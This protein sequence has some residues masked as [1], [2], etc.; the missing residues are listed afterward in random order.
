MSNGVTITWQSTHVYSW[1]FPEEEYNR[2]HDS[3][4]GL[5]G[6]DFDGV[7]A[8]L[9]GEDCNAYDYTSERTIIVVKPEVRP[10]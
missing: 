5:D 3:E 6:H 2:H 8:G 10:T 4:D 9:E 7:L 1:T